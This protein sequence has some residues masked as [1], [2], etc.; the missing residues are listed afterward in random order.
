MY[1]VAI[2]TDQLRK[3][4]KMQGSMSLIIIHHEHKCSIYQIAQKLFETVFLA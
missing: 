3:R 1:H 4:D 2:L